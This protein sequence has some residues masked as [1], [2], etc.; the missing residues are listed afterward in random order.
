MYALTGIYQADG[1]LAGELRYVLGRLMGTAH[2]ALCDITHG[3]VR[4][5]KAFIACR[6][7]LP[8][9]LKNVHLDERGPELRAFTEGKTPC[10]VAHTDQGLRLLMDAELL[11]ACAASV[12]R[13][14]E[15]LQEQMRSQGLVFGAE[16][17]G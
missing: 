9:P 6:Q 5:K 15:A 1:S 4:E 3:S 2:C 7:G 13:F 10:V 16:L 12:D 17:R 11:E 8:V 14:E